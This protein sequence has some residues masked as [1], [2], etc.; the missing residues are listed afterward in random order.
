MVPCGVVEAAI[1]KG[2]GRPRL[3][4]AFAHF[5]DHDPFS[6][7]LCSSAFLVAA[8]RERNATLVEIQGD[9][10]EISHVLDHWRRDE[11]GRPIPAKGKE[12]KE[13]P[14]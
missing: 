5:D 13:I 1:L 7:T 11:A 3:H 4:A 2:R 6:V 12:L 8:A 9:E 14:G 10:I